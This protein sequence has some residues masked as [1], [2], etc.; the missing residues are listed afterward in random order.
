MFDT[1]ADDRPIE[2]QYQKEIIR[3]VVTGQLTPKAAAPKLAAA[4]LPD[5]IP[6]I[7]SEEDEDGIL[8]DTERMFNITLEVLETDPKSAPTIRDLI[9]CMSQLPPALTK[10]GQQLCATDPPGRVWEDLRVSGQVSSPSARSICYLCE[11]GWII[12]I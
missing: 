1:S 10:S 11:N 4:T 6:D 2:W 9:V 12:S 8:S 3:E 7:E 5:P